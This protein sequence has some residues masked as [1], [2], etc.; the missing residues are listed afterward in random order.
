[1]SFCAPETGTPV[2]LCTQAYS[3]LIPH[4]VLAHALHYGSGPAA[5]PRG[6]AWVT[7]PGGWDG[8][9]LGGQLR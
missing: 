3:P 2:C 5:V 1:M 6:S 8:T 4:F 9:K 7:E